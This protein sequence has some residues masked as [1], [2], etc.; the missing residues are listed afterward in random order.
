MSRIDARI[1]EMQFLAK[2][3]RESDN[4]PVPTFRDGTPSP[5]RQM[6]VSMVHDGYVNGIEEVSGLISSQSPALLK[7]YEVQVGG[8]IFALLCGQQLKIK[9]S[10]KGRVRLSE[11][12]Q[13]LKTGRDR[14]ETGLL[15]AKRHVLIDLAMA[16]THASAA[17]PLSVVFLDMNG[18]TG[19]NLHGHDVGDGALR[20]FF[21]AAAA[22][23]G[24][25]GDVY[26]NGG[27]EVVAILPGV[28]DAAAAALLNGFVRQLGKEVLRLGDA[29]HEV[30]LT[31]SCGSVS[32]TDPTEDASAFLRRAD[33]VLLRAKPASG[34]PK[35]YVGR[36]SAFA[37][38]DGEVLVHD[39]NAIAP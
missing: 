35:V 25:R 26:R 6:V 23:L 19:I 8:N 17:E 1:R 30:R 29:K 12:E 36:V 9:I 14:D 4:L 3:D 5:E 18:L 11:L 20:A 33:Q 38:G 28:A 2:L 27:D 13:Q 37:V 10:H 39:P 21:Q 15:W 24:Q 7:H 34:T 22:T 16:V 32:T 31:T